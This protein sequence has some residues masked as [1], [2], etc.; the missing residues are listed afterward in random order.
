MTCAKTM[1]TIPAVIMGRPS[2]SK[3]RIRENAMEAIYK[4]LSYAIDNVFEKY[5]HK[6][7]KF[8]SV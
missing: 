8:Q 4:K 3:L 7:H 2:G 6:F 5:H 1:I